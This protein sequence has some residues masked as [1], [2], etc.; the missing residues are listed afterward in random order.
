[1]STRFIYFDPIY[2]CRSGLFISTR[3]I[4]VD[5]VYLCRPGLF[6]S[7]RF[8]NVD[9]VYNR[10]KFLGF[11]INLNFW[12]NHFG[13]YSAFVKMLNYSDDILRIL[14]DTI[15]DREGYID[16]LDTFNLLAG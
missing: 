2:K 6:I 13:L 8:I 12:K 3:F 5:L 16:P 14:C 10:P 9:P 15:F 11:L 7:T 1:M 4:N